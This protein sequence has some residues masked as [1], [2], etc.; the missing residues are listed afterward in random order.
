MNKWFRWYGAAS[1]IGILTGIGFIAYLL[2]DTVIRWTAEHGLSTLN[3]AEVNI[4][5]VEWQ[6]SPFKVDLINIEAT[7]PRA[8]ESNRAQIGKLT[9]QLS[10]RELMRGR[11]FARE[12][13][14]EGVAF[15]TERSSRGWVDRNPETEAARQ[16]W[17][18]QLAAWNVS[19]PDTEELIDRLALQ[20]EEKVEQFQANLAERREAVEE[21]REN[22]PDEE[23]LAEF[24]ERLEAIIESK[25]ESPREIL[26]ARENLN[27]L[28]DDVKSAAEQVEVFIAL[29]SDTLAVTRHEL[30]ELQQVAGG[31]LS[32]LNNLLS[33]S[34]DSLPNWSGILF[35]PTVEKWVTRGNSIFQW[36]APKLKSARDEQ[37]RPSR[38]EGRYVDLSENRPKFLI[39]QINVNFAQ[40]QGAL[41][42]NINNLTYQHGLIGEPTTF[43]VNAGATERWSSLALSGDMS[44]AGGQLLGQQQWQ[45]LGLNLTDM[46]LLNSESLTAKLLQAG[47]NTQGSTRVEG[48]ELSG[49]GG[50]DLSSVEMDFGGESPVAPRLEQLFSSIQSFSLGL[51]LSGETTSPSFAIETDLDEQLAGAFANQLRSGL[52]GQVEAGEERLQNIIA[53][54]NSSAT[55][56]LSA[57]EAQ[58]AEGQSLQESLTAVLETEL[59]DLIES[60]RDR[61]LRLLRER[62]GGN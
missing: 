4:E 49:Q 43:A 28:K 45:V 59:D 46:T 53:P 14:V 25:P 62:I 29:S 22:L 60:E 32:R 15:D 21:A 19:L 2:S 47:V 48:S 56:W 39:E 30:T 20:T 57:V 54:A 35:G 3:N 34:P 24:Q 10:F 44:F 26:E 36:V 38:W 13:A 42:V 52:E 51:N 23:Q 50:F 6:A 33:L 12:V 58:R 7:N 8:P 27:D 41:A 5:Q 17:Q 61:A 31:D 55:Q 18:E 40:W 16:N 1:F 11:F 37:Q 9:V